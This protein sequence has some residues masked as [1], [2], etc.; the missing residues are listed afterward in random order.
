MTINKILVAT[1][2]SKQSEVASQHALG[3]AR[4][5]KAE[6]VVAHAMTIPTLDF[7]VP[8]AVPGPGFSD[9]EIEQITG[10]GR[11]RLNEECESLKGQGVTVSAHF[12]QDSPSHGLLHAA[13][14]LQ[15]DVLVMGTHSRKGLTRFLLGSVAQWVA[16]RAPCDV[17]AARSEAP[18]GGY[19]KILVPTDFSDSSMHALKRATQLVEPGGVIDLVHCWNISVGASSLWGIGRDLRR[20]IQ[21]AATSHGEKLVAEYADVDVTINFVAEETAARH[22]I[23]DRLEGSDYDLVAMGSHGLKGVKKL[24]LGSLAEAVLRHAKHSVYIARAQAD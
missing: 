15:A 11:K 8:Y 24:M 4:R 5:S 16:Q 9:E 17:L 6:L 2:F 18:S 12:I 10:D 19:K 3:I 20:S 7:A 1:D 23:M 14:E 13:I 22:A 21:N